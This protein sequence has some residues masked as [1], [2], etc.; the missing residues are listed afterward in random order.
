MQ[1]KNWDKAIECYTRAIELYKDDAIYYANRSLCYLKKEKYTFSKLKKKHIYNINKFFLLFC[2]KITRSGSRL[3]SRITIRSDICQSFATAKLCIR[4]SRFFTKS[5]LWLGR[6]FT[7]G[8]QQRGGEKTT[9]IFD[10]TYG[11]KRGMFVFIF[12]SYCHHINLI[13]PFKL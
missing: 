7:V 9:H 2:F 4:R 10:T 5:S 3:Y 13:I 11:Y 1:Q 6:Y 8:T 12:L